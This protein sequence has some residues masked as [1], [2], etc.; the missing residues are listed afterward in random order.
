MPEEPERLASSDE[1]DIA[2]ARKTVMEGYGKTVDEPRL[3]RAYTTLTQ[4]SPSFKTVETAPYEVCLLYI[5]AKMRNQKELGQVEMC[6]T[7]PGSRLY[8]QRTEHVD[9]HRHQE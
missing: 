7:Q 4:R 5:M 6:V 2:G 9:K 1:K 8:Q 3:R